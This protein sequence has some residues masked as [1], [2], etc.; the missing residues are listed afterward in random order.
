MHGSKKNKKYKLHKLHKPYKSHK[1]YK[2]NNQTFKKGGEVLDVGAYGCVFYPALKCK[3]RKTRTN[4]ISKLSLKQDSIDEWNIYKKV[5]TLL[6]VIPNY[7]KYFLLDNFSTCTPDK[8]TEQDKKKMEKCD[9]LNEYNSDNM[10]DNLNELM[11]INMPYGGKNLDKMISN[12]LISYN[13]VNLLLSNLINKAIIP[14]NK[15]NIYHFDIKANNILY[16]NNNV[17]LID[18]GKL[19]FKDKNNSIPKN[20]IR[21]IGI[22]FNSPIGNILFNSF[23]LNRI[24]YSLKGINLTI[25]GIANIFKIIYN[26]LTNN[27]S[28]GHTKL[29]EEILENIL[30]C[31]N[32]KPIK[33]KLVIN[34]LI[35]NYCAHVIFNFYDY[36]KQEFDSQKYFDTIYSKNVDILGVLS[37]Y[38]NYILSEHLSYSNHFK[39]QIIDIIYD[40]FFSYKYS[41]KV[42]PITQIMAELNKIKM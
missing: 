22:Q 6:K 9:I 1:L 7:K 25:P 16:K 41:V 14:M 10:N 33:T 15:L 31:K 4:G 17:K 29:L 5:I 37:C 11:I 27:Y 35:C 23:V 24:N 3:N 12:N 26:N 28:E 34:D 2:Q 42:I 40:C 21:T 18:F 19:D 36:K 8:L 32:L 30:K 38:I 13:D 39:T 20:L